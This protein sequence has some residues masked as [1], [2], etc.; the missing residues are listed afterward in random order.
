[1][2]VEGDA[3]RN[4]VEHYRTVVS[5]GGFEHGAELAFVAGEGAT[6]EGCAE[7]DGQAAGINGR[8]I[9]EHSRFQLG[10]E[11]GGGGE[12]AFGEAVDAVIFD[13]VD[14]GKIAAHEVHELADA[15]GSGVTIAADADGDQVAISKHRSCGHGGHASMDW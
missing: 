7:F 10:T 2:I 6:D 13:D 9:V 14:H 1:M 12:L 5:D 15:D 3:G 11:I 4:H 8:E